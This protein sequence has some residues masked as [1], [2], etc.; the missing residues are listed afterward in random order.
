[1]TRS[2]KRELERSVEELV[3]DLPESTQPTGGVELSEA[4]KHDVRSLLRYRQ[5]V[6]ADTGVHIDDRDIFVELMATARANVDAG[7][8]T[9]DVI[10]ASADAI[11]FEPG[12]DDAPTD[13]PSGTHSAP[14]FGGEK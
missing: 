4:D 10:E 3:A 6:A 14:L 2:S 5:Q 12:V 1:M 9:V 7:E 8:V 11:G 13:H